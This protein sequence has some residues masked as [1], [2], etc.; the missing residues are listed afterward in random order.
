MKKIKLNELLKDQ[1]RQI[2]NEFNWAIELNNYSKAQELFFEKIKISNQLKQ[3][4]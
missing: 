2:E 3:I 4:T 1:L